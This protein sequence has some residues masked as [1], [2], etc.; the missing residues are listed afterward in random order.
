MLFRSSCALVAA[1]TI[2]LA[3]A[4]ALSQSFT[5]QGQLKDAGVPANGSFDM[6]FQVYPLPL[7]GLQI[8]VTDTR[9]A[10]SVVNGL[11][12]TEVSALSGAV[13]GP[14][15]Y[16]DIAI[17][18]TGSTG[19][20][21]PISPR[22]RIT[23]A[24][25]AQKS[26]SERWTQV[27][28]A[29]RT[30]PGIT[31]VLINAASSI[32]SDS[33]LTVSRNT[34]P[35]SRFAGMYVGGTD[36]GTQAYYGWFANGLS[37]A[38]AIVSGLTGNFLLSV[39]GDSDITVTPAGLVGVGV[40]PTGPERLRVAG[41]SVVVGDSKATTFS[42]ATPRV[43]TLGIPPEAFRASISTNAGIF[44]SGGGDA[45]FDSAVGAAVMVAPVNLPDGA[46]VTAFE[47]FYRDNSAAVDLAVSLNLRLYASSG[48]AQ[49]ANIATSG[50]SASA[51]SAID[52]TIVDATIDNATRVYMVNVFCSDWA[53]SSTT[54]KGVKI[55]YRLDGPE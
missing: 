42:Y 17:R 55:T 52:T 30:D 19:A 23:V 44:G 7:G 34:S 53:G 4:P 11:F 24:P 38:E 9:A 1:M 25:L 48:Y 29:L 27:G 47:V 5:Y 10:V 37:K 12:T 18:P 14:D 20:F 31:N 32:I 36:A 49:M 13:I 46:V 35:S 16:L 45:L 2:A 43:K 41:D 3:S 51:L 33:V 21:T 26:L 40:T 15:L 39:G 50:A 28:T 6:Q 22:T 8:G 54:I